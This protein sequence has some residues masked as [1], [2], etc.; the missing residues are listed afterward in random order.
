MAGR[1]TAS[2]GTARL[3]WLGGGA[4]AMGGG[5][6]AMHYT[7]MLA[8]RLPLRVYYHIPT[9]V[10]S[11]VAAVVASLIALY[12][13]SRPRMTAVHVAAG[14]LLMGAGIATMHY[15]GMA[16]MRLEAMHHY[17]RGLWLLS[18]L[19]AVVIAL[20]AVGLI[21]YFR[22]ENRGKKMQVVIAIVMGLRFRSCTTPAWLRSSSLP[23]RSH[24]T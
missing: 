21:F 23:C 17:H 7:G 16:A 15:T 13:V 1:I 3:A 10:L 11:L 6:W 14:S 20:A 24:R 4:V 19:L 8:Y 18:V 22:E 9:V 5:I 2:R 12:V